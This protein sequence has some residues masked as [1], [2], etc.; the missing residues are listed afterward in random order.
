[1]VVLLKEGM[2]GIRESFDR[3]QATALRQSVSHVS[4]MELL[5]VCSY[6]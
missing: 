3:T 2:G 6:F 4:C 5:P 1:M